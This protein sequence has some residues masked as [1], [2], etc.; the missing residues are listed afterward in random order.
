MLLDSIKKKVWESRF[1]QQTGRT[2]YLSELRDWQWLDKNEI[3]NLQ[4]VRLES[5]LHH[6][7]KHIPYYKKILLESEIVDSKGKVNLNNFENI[8]LLTKEVIRTEF[9]SLKSLDILDRKWYRNTSG[10]STG[11]PVTFIQ[12]DYYK[13]W[14]SAI[15]LLF[16]EWTGFRPGEKK[17]VLWGSKRDLLVGKETIRSQ[18][19]TWLRNELPLNSFKM[20]TATMESYCKKINDFKPKQIKAYAGSIFELALYIKENNLKI[21][22]PES[23]VTS[24]GTLYP[25]MREL[26]EHVFDSPVFNRYGSREVGGI[27]CECEEHKGLH[28]CTPTQYIEVLREDGTFAEPGEIGEIVVTSLINYAMPLIRY[29]IGDMGAWSE[30]ECSCGRGFPLLERITGRTTDTFITEDKTKIYGEYFTH[31]FFHQDWIKKFQVIQEEINL[32][33]ILIV[34]KE[35]VEKPDVYYNKEIIDINQKVK[36]VMGKNCNVHINFLEDIPPSASG[37][38][39]YTISKINT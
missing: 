39:R 3:V 21:H 35:K 10:G 36:F 34:L 25:Q 30:K 28:V 5:L 22:S 14:N 18:A 6:A 7:Y 37:K 11:E 31:I 16:E 20:S 15:P 26:I 19:S 1:S 29:R 8:P 32:V 27:A 4:Q 2:K 23:I 33:N 12:D 24:A 17:A 38:Y 13:E 9:E